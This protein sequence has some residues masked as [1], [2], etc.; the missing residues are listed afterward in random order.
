M[1]VVNIALFLKTIIITL[2]FIP[3]IDN[4]WEI[5]LDISFIEN[6]HY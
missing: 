3:K 2:N 6:D 4:K 1:Y 5:K